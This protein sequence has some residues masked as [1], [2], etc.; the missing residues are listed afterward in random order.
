MGALVPR[1]SSSEPM[2]ARLLGLALGGSAEVIHFASFQ[3]A[4]GGSSGEP[5]EGEPCQ[6]VASLLQDVSI[7]KLVGDLKSL[8]VYLLRNGKRLRGGDLDSTLI[9]YLLDP[10]RRDYSLQRLEASFLGRNSS[11]GPV[12]SSTPTGDG[13][14]EACVDCRRLLELETVLKDRLRE[15]GLERLYRE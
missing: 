15:R 9:A 3:M 7:P 4:P 6:E 12:G 13:E 11:G 5:G 1:F 2:R 10:D 14:L 8:E